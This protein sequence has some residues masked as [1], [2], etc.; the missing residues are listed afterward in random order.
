MIESRYSGLPRMIMCVGLFAITLGG[1]GSSDQVNQPQAIAVKLS[2]VES[3]TLVDSSEFIGTSTARD[4][5][6][7]A[8]RIDGRIL[9]IF[10]RQGD[11]VRR[12]DKIVRLEPTRDREN[13]NAASQS[14]NVERARLGQAVAELRTA[15]AN[16]A[17][18]AAQVKSAKADLQTIE[19]EVELAQINLDRT[20]KL[21]KDGVLPQQNLDDST[22]DL[23]TNIAQRNSRRESLNAAI[24]SQQAADQQVDQAQ[25]NVDSQKA[26]IARSKAELRAVGQNLE[27]NTIRAPID[28]VIGSFDSKKVGDYVSVGEQLTTLTNNQTLELNINI[29]IENRDQI[30]RGLAVETIGNNE[31]HIVRGQINYIAPLVQQNAQSILTKATFPNQRRLRDREYVRVRVIWNE[32]PGILIPTTAISTL[33]GQSFVY[34]AQE[35]STQSGERSMMVRQQPVKLGR[36]QDQAYQILSGIKVGDRIATSNILSLKDNTPITDAETVGRLESK[37]QKTQGTH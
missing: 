21:V 9:E 31:R 11:R 27:F 6:S 20:K 17:A 37:I 19:A 29:P 26:A 15:Q 13:V 22:R 8:P 3:D 2:T 7:L 34:I 23:K 28:G 24:E 32:R 14:V 25:A 10:V 18:A 36:I 16:R 35:Q 30:K 33:G 4:R 12:G 1:C 5:V